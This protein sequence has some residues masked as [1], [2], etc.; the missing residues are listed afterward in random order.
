[1]GNESELRSEATA[2]QRSAHIAALDGV[3]G[4]AILLVLW[5]HFGP[6]P[7]RS[8]FTGFHL[9][10]HNL[11]H[12]G[13]AGVDLFFVLSGFLITGILLDAKAGLSRQGGSIARCFGVFYARRALRIFPLYY[14]ALAI[15]AFVT[16][17][18]ADPHESAVWRG[19]SPWLWLYSGNIYNARHGWVAG[20]HGVILNHLWSLAVEEQFYLAWPAIILFCGSR[21]LRFGCIAAIPFSIALRFYIERVTGNNYAATLLMPCRIDAFAVGGLLAISMRESGVRSTLRWEWTM[22]GV[23]AVALL[24]MFLDFTWMDILGRTMLAVLFGGLILVAIQSRLR[25]VFE[26]TFLRLLGRYSY[27]LYVLHLLLY[28]WINCSMPAAQFGWLLHWIGCAAL[29]FLLAFCS[30]HLL[31]RRFIRLKQCF[32]W[33]EPPG[34]WRPTVDRPSS[35]PRMARFAAR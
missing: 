8:N 29:S 33:N 10:L 25:T 20:P 26:S 3:R 31:E 16:T 22:M 13:W 27:G 28:R 5:E 18:R 32:A 1:M 14:A 19:W 15:V 24:P 9:I 34:N 2:L 6:T 30:W 7:A 12:A 4:L 11:L 35:L 21:A 17:L 23:S